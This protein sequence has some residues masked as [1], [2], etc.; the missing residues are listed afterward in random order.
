MTV[1]AV[2]SV[3]AESQKAT[4]TTLK[5]KRCGQHQV[6]KTI[7]SKPTWMVPII[8]LDFPAI[9]EGIVIG[10]RVGM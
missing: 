2:S 9:L 6:T 5:E 1:T 4:N 8:E 7:E 10:M 3:I